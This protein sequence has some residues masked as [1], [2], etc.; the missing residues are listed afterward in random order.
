MFKNRES[1]YTVHGTRYSVFRHELQ[2]YIFSFAGH[3]MSPDPSSLIRHPGSLIPHPSSLTPH[4]GSR[5]TVIV[6][7]VL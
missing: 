4:P 6:F 1:R 3:G 5:Q 7:A 2:R